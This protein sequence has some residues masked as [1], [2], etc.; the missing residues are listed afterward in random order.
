[1]NHTGKYIIKKSVL[2]NKLKL[3]YNIII[4]ISKWKWKWKWNQNGSEIKSNK[5]KIKI[6]NNVTKTWFKIYKGTN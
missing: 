3:V 2:K 1:M 6:K 5:I 4:I